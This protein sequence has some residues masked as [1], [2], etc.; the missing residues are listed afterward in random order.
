M[1]ES[2]MGDRWAA[3]GNNRLSNSWRVV[4][5]IND[6]MCAGASWWRMIGAPMLNA[7]GDVF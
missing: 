3:V 7:R 2:V 1:H 6:A 5:H 4:L